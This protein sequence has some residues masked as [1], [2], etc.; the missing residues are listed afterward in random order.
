[1]ARS[2]CARQRATTRR[3]DV[4]SLL[5]LRIRRIA[6]VLVLYA[7][8]LTTAQ[9]AN[10]HEDIITRVSKDGAV[11]DT[12]TGGAFDVLGQDFI[13]PTT[14]HAGD[15]VTVCTEADSQPKGA[16]VYDLN[17]HRLGERLVVIRRAK[18]RSSKA[19]STFH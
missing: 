3:V 5:A 19:N 17:N 10:C 9:A 12:K 15:H 14:W 6:S 11:I 2:C 4:R 16:P 18:Q 8:V 7:L 1:M 13:D